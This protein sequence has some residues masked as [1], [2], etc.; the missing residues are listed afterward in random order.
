MDAV[1]FIKEFD[2]MCD[3]Y[4]GKCENCEGKEFKAKYG[5]EGEACWDVAGEHPEVYVPF[6]EKWSQEH[7]QKTRLDDFKEKFPNAKYT[8]EGIPESCAEFLGYCGECSDDDSKSCA[9]CWNQ[10]LEDKA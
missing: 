7:P 10:P 1:K 6:V 3:S 4:G 2:R 9:E 5:R 8:A